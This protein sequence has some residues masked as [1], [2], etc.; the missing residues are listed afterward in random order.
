[1]SNQTLVK[2]YEVET[3]VTK[4][5]I[6]KHGTADAQVVPAAAVSDSLLGVVAE[7]DGAVGEHVDV[8]LSGI[9]DVEYGGAVTRG[10][11]LT[12][13]ASGLAVTAAPAAGVNNRII[14]FANV[15]GVSGDVGSVLITPGQI[16]GA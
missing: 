11:P 3:T 2:A 5:R 14:G 12:S 10:D 7:L 13:D 9:A 4:Y 6:V 15:S 1:M 16:Q 8:V